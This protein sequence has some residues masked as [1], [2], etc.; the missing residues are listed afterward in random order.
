MR[1]RGPL[2]RKLAAAVWIGALSIRRRLSPPCR[3]RLIWI[4]RVDWGGFAVDW[5]AVWS[6]LALSARLPLRRPCPGRRLLPAG[7]IE[8]VV[9]VILFWRSP[10]ITH[11]VISLAHQQAAI[12]CRRILDDC[13]PLAG[14]L[15][16]MVLD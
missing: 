2:F 9:P 1:W 6:R 14:Q 16:M 13:C 3:K 7:E 11:I 4:V 12:R 10:S 15:S 8:I 5:V